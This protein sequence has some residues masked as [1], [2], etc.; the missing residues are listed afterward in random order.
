MFY[1][2]TEHTTGN[3]STPWHSHKE[4]EY[5]WLKPLKCNEYGNWMAYYYSLSRNSCLNTRN[6]KISDLKCSQTSAKRKWSTQAALSLEIVNIHQFRGSA[7]GRGGNA[8]W[9]EMVRSA[10][11]AVPCS[12][13][14]GES[15]RPSL[16]VNRM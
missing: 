5:H 3:V 14:G 1:T 4:G 10:F 7:K 15:S 16:H 11:G 2:P 13:G 8:V 6:L 12:I 9:E